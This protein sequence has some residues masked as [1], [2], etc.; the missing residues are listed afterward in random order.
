MNS[1]QK[2]VA[3]GA[4][5]GV[6]CMI[7]SVVLLYYL[8]PTIPGMDAALDRLVFAFKMNVLAITPLFVMIASVGNGRFV[9]RAIDPMRGEE[10]MMLII[11][12]RVADNTLQQYLLFLVGTLALSTFLTAET[13]RVISALVIVFIAA[14]ILFWI[15]YRKNPLYRAPGMAA[16][17]YMNMGILAVVVYFIINTYLLSN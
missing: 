10:D 5:S 11:N 13:I 6:V 16:T 8:L 3:I 4:G 1:D 17:S 12:G 14:R 2:T 9:S 7:L 15:G